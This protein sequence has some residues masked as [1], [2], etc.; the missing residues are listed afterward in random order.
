[1]P[2]VRDNEDELAEEFTV[3]SPNPLARSLLK[4][5]AVGPSAHVNVT[6]LDFNPAAMFAGVKT[7]LETAVLIGEVTHRPIRIVLLRPTGL[8]GDDRAQFVKERRSA[9]ERAFPETEWSIVC[10]D[11]LTSLTFGTDDI[12]VATHWMTAHALDLASRVGAIDLHRVIY[13]VQ[14]YEPDHF[15]GDRDRPAA[16]S[17]YRAGF[18]LLVNSRQVAAFLRGHGVDVNDEHVFAPQFDSRYLRTVASRRSTET[19][20]LIF[21]Y[22]RPSTPRNM[23]G[24]G[25]ET[26]RRAAS[27]FARRGNEVEFVMAGESGPDIDLA[28]GF[29]LRNLGVLERTAYFDEIARVDVGLTLQATPHPSHLPFDLAISGAFAVTNEVDGSRNQMHPRI[30]ATSSTPEALSTLLV[31][32]VDRAR[33]GARVPIGYLPVRDGQLG[34]S[35]RNAVVATTRDAGMAPM[36]RH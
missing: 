25:I 36:S 5:S 16:E 11:E 13:L 26:L 35:L 9:L 23:F 1:M 10:D 27:E 28:N 6:L 7:A 31:A 14:D 29:T 19:V 20:P 3:S 18:V 15:A 12:W 17:T 4:V 33:N 24:L 32:M 21:F 8:L 34:S 22:G 2:S 30:V